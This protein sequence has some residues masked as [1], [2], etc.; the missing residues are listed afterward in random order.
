[1][2]IGCTEYIK[3]CGKLECDVEDFRIFCTAVFFI[4]KILINEECPDI[5]RYPGHYE[6]NI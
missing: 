5:F 3:I 6:K 2:K 1:M 4:K